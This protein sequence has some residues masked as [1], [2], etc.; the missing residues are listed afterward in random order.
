MG[1]S[2]SLLHGLVLTLPLCLR[3]HGS[4]ERSRCCL[5][6]T[7]AWVPFAAAIRPGAA[8]LLLQSRMHWFVTSVLD[9]GSVSVPGLEDVAPCQQ[10]RERDDSGC[11][12]ACS[13]TNAS[14][15]AIAHELATG[16]KQLA[17]FLSSFMV[18]SQ[19][20]ASAIDTREDTS[21]I[22]PCPVH[23]PRRDNSM[24]SAHLC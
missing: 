13:S 3:G 19:Q 7:G 11:A 9:D 16:S 12:H 18:A 24:S 20:H 2:L 1:C 8:A 15:A 5:W 17:F 22:L 4:V 6:R 14:C 10:Q 21:S 23:V